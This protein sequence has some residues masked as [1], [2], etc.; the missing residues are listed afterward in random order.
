MPRSRPFFQRLDVEAAHADDGLV[1]DGGS[2]R[3]RADTALLTAHKI[4]LIVLEL[5]KDHFQITALDEPLQACISDLIA[6]WDKNERSE[7]SG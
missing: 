4:L 1:F 3:K 2:Q 6:I 7:K 5:H